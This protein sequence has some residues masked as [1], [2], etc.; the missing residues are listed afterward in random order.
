MAAGMIWDWLWSDTHT[1]NHFTSIMIWDWLWSVMHSQS[2]HVNLQTTICPDVTSNKQV[3]LT[4]LSA[5]VCVSLDGWIY[6]LCTNV[7]A[8]CVHAYEWT[9][10]T[11][12]LHSL[13]YLLYFDVPNYCIELLI[14][15]IN[16]TYN[17]LT[18]S[19][20]I[21]VYIYFILSHLDN[22]V[23]LICFRYSISYLKG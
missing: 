16:S 21:N 18:I 8:F 14:I 19:C 2:F 3:I 11:D 6:Y 12:V 22:I 23:V 20:S 7:Y 10:Y 5:S 1:V 13:L 4:L 17:Y 15:K 9:Y